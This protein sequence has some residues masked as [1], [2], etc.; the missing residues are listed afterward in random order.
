MCIGVLL[1]LLCSVVVHALHSFQFSPCFSSLLYVHVTSLRV[2]A[3]LVRWCHGWS[4]DR[5]YDSLKAAP[6]QGGLLHS[7][8]RRAPS[9]FRAQTFFFLLITSIP[10]SITFLSRKAHACQ[11]PH[12]DVERP[13]QAY[14]WIRCYSLDVASDC[15]RGAPREQGVRVEQQ[16]V[17]VEQGLQL[18]GYPADVCSRASAVLVRLI[19]GRRRGGGSRRRQIWH[20]VPRAEVR[21]VSRMGWLPTIWAGTEQLVVAHHTGQGLSIHTGMRRCA[22]LRQYET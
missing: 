8:L 12:P 6:R 20:R 21:I 13:P 17:C 18:Q 4:C 1:D 22:A 7:T 16:G 15:P 14:V 9:L 10:R 5:Q 11:K 3:A 2:H 19:R